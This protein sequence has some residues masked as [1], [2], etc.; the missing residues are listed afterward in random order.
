MFAPSTVEAVRCTGGWLFDQVM[1]GWDVTVMT[2]DRGDPRPLH[3]L[4]ARVRD[5]DSVPDTPTMGQCLRA[6]AV[7]IDLYESD[8]RVRQ[9]VCTAFDGGDADIRF[10]GDCWPDGF[11]R[12][13][14]VSHELSLAAR[15]FK[16]QAMAAAM[17][18]AGLTA[19]PEPADLSAQV[20]VFRRG[21]IRRS[22]PAAVG[23]GAE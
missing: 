17:T 15:A 6:V 20:E 23:N 8:R 18:V 2:E 3:I 10:W 13:G 12:P 21:E 16:A 9:M 7:R 11:R 19:A 1:A 4:G 5:L 14:P 22:A